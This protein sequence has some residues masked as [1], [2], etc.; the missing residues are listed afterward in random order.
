VRGQPSLKGR[1]A[2]SDGAAS[3]ASREARAWLACVRRDG[4]IPKRRTVPAVLIM[5]LGS[6]RGHGLGVACY[7]RRLRWSYLETAPPS[8]CTLTW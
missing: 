7:A 8:V 6:S 2:P 5:M 4:L 3:F 1:A